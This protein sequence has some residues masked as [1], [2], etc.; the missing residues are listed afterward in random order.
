MSLYRLDLFENTK[1]H[2]GF[3]FLQKPT[4]QLFVAHQF[5]AY[6]M[7]SDRGLIQLHRSNNWI[8]CFS[9]EGSMIDRRLVKFHSL[10]H[11][12]ESLCHLGCLKNYHGCT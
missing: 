2:W 10:T 7:S 9:L 3:S 8:L 4:R 1:V 11:V 6:L 5:E 12:K